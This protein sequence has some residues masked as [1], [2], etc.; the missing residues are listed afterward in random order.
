MSM[1]KRFVG[2]LQ[3]KKRQENSPLIQ[4]YLELA[5]APDF[6]YLVA[7]G[8]LNKLIEETP[9]QDELLD[10]LLEDALFASLY[11]T[12]YEE[13]CFA[14][15]ENA[16]L[17]LPLIKK[18]EEDQHGR[19]HIINEQTNLHFE[20]IRKGGQCPGCSC[21]DNHHD[22]VELIAPYQKKDL[23]FFKEL[24]MG[25]QNIQLAMEILVYE[26]IP[27]RPGL[28]KELSAGQILNFRKFLFEYRGN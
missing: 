28:T 25:M 24:Y 20:F 15:R 22:V 12:F 3:A 23:T 6:P 21:C 19:E 9:D 17:T 8:E 2:Q 10:Y 18:F 26:Q 13:L 7:V 27:T 1:V 14:I 11:A 5:N 16:H 4:Q